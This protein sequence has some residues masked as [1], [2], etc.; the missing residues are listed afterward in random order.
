MRRSE[1]INIISTK[2]ETIPYFRD[3][4]SLAFAEQLLHVIEYAGICPLF[5]YMGFGIEPVYA[6]EDEEDD[7]V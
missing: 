7:G 4:K 3:G 2:L 1:M 6:W 5:T